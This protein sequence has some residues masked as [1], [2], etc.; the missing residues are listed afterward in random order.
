MIIKQILGNIYHPILHK[1]R[2]SPLLH[3]SAISKMVK[4]SIA[5]DEKRKSRLYIDVTNIHTKDTGTGIA[6]VTK[7][8]ASRIVNYNK[9]YDVICIY[10]KNFDGY[11]DCKTNEFITFSNEDIYFGLD[12]G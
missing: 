4:K 12:N 1:M 2:T 6:R 8:I 3:M 11:F 9:K 7:E 10:N 5:I